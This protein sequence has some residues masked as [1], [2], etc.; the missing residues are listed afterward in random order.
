MLTTLLAMFYLWYTASVLATATAFLASL[1]TW[2]D[3]GEPLY[4][5]A[6]EPSELVLH[7]PEQSEFVTKLVHGGCTLKQ[8]ENLW[9]ICQNFD[10]S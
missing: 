9:R 3:Q 10:R 2:V 7:S 4:V 8:A 6:V 1:V 5:E